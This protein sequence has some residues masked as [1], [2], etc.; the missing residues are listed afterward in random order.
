MTT[1]IRVLTIVALSGLLV[2]LGW[3]LRSGLD[4]DDGILYN[5]I[6]GTG[7]KSPLLSACNSAASHD[8]DRYAAVFGLSSLRP[9]ADPDMAASVRG[10][11]TGWVETHDFLSLEPDVC[12]SVFDNEHALIVAWVGPAEAHTIQGYTEAMLLIK[13]NLADLDL[14]GFHV[15]TSNV[16]EM[17]AI[18]P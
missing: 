1:P 18:E 14:W 4:P 8:L 3:T 2:A 5:R 17:L 11:A 12:V 16:R 13:V 9:I 7:R 6:L 15:G 10:L